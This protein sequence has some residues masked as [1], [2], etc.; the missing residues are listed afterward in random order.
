MWLLNTHTGSVLVSERG[1]ASTGAA[2]SFD[3]IH[4][5]VCH[6]KMAFAITAACFQSSGLQ[7]ENSVSHREKGEADRAFKE[8]KKN[9]HTLNILFFKDRELKKM[10]ISIIKIELS[11]TIN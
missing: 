4:I 6:L 9:I 11:Q 2:E 3:I 8:Q 1:A 7:Q 10:K 5:I